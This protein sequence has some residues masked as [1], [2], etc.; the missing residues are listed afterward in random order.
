[1]RPPVPSEWGT[2]INADLLREWR[3]TRRITQ[4][5]LGAILGMSRQAISAWEANRADIPPFLHL[6]LES[7]DRR[8]NFAARPPEPKQGP[9][10]RTAVAGARNLVAAREELARQLV[11]P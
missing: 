3:R 1:M 9:P 2:P 11:K 10:R 5:E 6:A 8:L 7:I 4:P